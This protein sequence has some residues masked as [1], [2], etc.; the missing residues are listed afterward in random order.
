MALA[1]RL[2]RANLTDYIDQQAFLNADDIAKDVN[3]ADVESAALEAARE[4]L[5]R[6]RSRLA[7]RLPFCIETTLATRTLLR[8]TE[9]ARDIGYR[10]KLVFL[11]TPFADINELRVKQRVMAGGHNI[12]TDTIRRRHALGLKY[13]SGCW[14][15]C[16]E[17]IVFDART[18]SPFEMLRKD[19]RG[20][21]I[22]DT[23]GWTL[24]TARVEASGGAP[25]EHV[26]VSR[27]GPNQ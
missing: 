6:R 22:S 27:T 23:A 13:L 3:P 2:A 18:R 9:Q 1:R 26:S 21:R 20:T 17:G 10:A 12:E 11:F 15:A 14:A 4:M 19:E 25:L 7:Q 5:N 24:L 16:D 8:F